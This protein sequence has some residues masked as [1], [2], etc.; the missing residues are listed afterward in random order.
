VTLNSIR[1]LKN[2]VL[3]LLPPSRAEQQTLSGLF[4][5]QAW[6]PV[7]SYGRVLITGPQC[8]D[9]R[10]GDLMAFPPTA[11]DPVPLNETTEAL[12]LLESD[13]AAIIRSKEQR[14]T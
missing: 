5:A 8:R 7:S 12:F 4:I 13:I 6:T 14:T 3:V 1:V 11:G 9:V 2:R 10:E